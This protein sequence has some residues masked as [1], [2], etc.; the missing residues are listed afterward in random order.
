MDGL[1][2]YNK[3]PEPIGQKKSWPFLKIVASLLFVLAV[4]AAGVMIGR[5]DKI[6]LRGLSATPKTTQT[7]LDYSSV[8]QVYNLLKADFDGALDNNI[9]LDGLKRGLV[10]AAGDPYTE[11]LNAADA[12][13]FD[14]QLSGSFTG[15]GAELGT[16]DE[17]NILIVAPLA[18]YPAEKAG[19]QPKDIISAID[20][21]TT[22]SMSV[23]SAVKKI[24]G[25]ANTQVTLTII[26]G[27]AKPFDVT[28]TRTQIT[29]PSVESKIEGNIGYLKIS[30]FTN[31]T[32]ESASAA[33]KSFKEQGLKGVVLDV[34]GNPGG[35]LSGAVD[36]AS[37]W[38]EKGKTV[39]SERRGQQVLSTDYSTGTATLNGLPT[40]VLIDEGS[41]S[42]SEITAGALHDNEIATV[43][44]EK[45]FGKGSV[46]Q[47]ERLL[48]GAA[49][50]VTI[51][52]WYTPKGVNID[53]QGITPDVQVGLS[54]D[55]K[56]AGRDPQK[57]KAFE[58]VRQKITP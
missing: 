57:D 26:R 11:Y 48:G 42:A 36:I 25:P 55:D 8:E 53:Q 30:Q 3:L 20:G 6:H 58:I 19:L 39:V 52:R 1:N 40:A 49:L 28:I 7:Q 24:R 27:S 21:Q 45:S 4:F 14:K 13:E 31:D 5:G 37:L 29:L 34:R 18:G 23:N 43:V 54:D 16:D 12:E 46:Q 9:L 56:K 33:A 38:L 51:A 15:I 32:V 2:S 41:A 10:E 44:G 47:V 35:Y 22:A 50:K 17:N